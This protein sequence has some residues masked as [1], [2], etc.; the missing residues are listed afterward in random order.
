M[1]TCLPTRDDELDEGTNGLII[2][3][4]EAPD[5]AFVHTYAPTGLTSGLRTIPQT[6]ILLNWS[7]S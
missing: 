4:D 1:C 7:K 6:L 2:E 5:F 3:N